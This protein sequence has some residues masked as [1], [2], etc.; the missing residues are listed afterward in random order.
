MKPGVAENETLVEDVLDL[1]AFALTADLRSFTETA[2]RMGES[3]ATISRRIARLES[4]LGVSLLRRTPRA[5]EPTDDGVAY[6]IRVAEILE[7]L[8]DANATVRHAHAEPSGVLRVTTPPG[9]EDVLAPVFA[10]FIAQFPHVV[11]SALVSERFIDLEAEHIDVAVRATGEL[12]DSTLVAHR[13]FESDA[14]AVAAPAYLAAHGTP[15]RPSE[16][17]AH[18]IVRLGPPGARLLAMQRDDEAPVELRL[19]CAL[20]T[21]DIRFARAMAL[22]GAGIA[23]LPRIAVRRELDD[24]SL[25]QVLRAYVVR[26]PTL[27][28]LHRGGRFLAPKVRAFRELALRELAHRRPR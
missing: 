2:K 15:R 28:L 14:V 3:K 6:R 19:A 4:A 5:V 16:L 11:V 7:L 9:F 25:T 12:A 18:R 1:Q 24:G 8:A 20:A 21:S 13:L 22:A 17:A 10:R 26:G 23:V 27:Y